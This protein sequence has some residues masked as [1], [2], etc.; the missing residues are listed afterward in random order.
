MSGT[1]S[2]SRKAQATECAI[3]ISHGQPSDPDLAE[4]ELEL[5]AQAVGQVMTRTAPGWRVLS[6][7][8]AASGRLEAAVAEAGSGA[9]VYPMFMTDGWFTR[10]NLPRRL[11]AAGFAGVQ[12]APFGVD[13]DLPA[14]AAD[15]L[16]AEI[17]AQG[18]RPQDTRLVLAAHGSGRSAG[19]ARDTRAF[20]AAL[21]ARLPLAGIF[22]GFV[23]ESP[24]IA[25]AARDLG[26]QALCLPFFAA[27]RGHVMED[28][29]QGLDA[30][31]FTG[32][33]LDPLGL[34]PQ[35]PQLVARALCRARMED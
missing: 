11:A 35:V 23:E 7:T 13:P 6:A 5:L 26:A 32:L 24:G 20:A 16:G 8:L 25:E 10:T 30:A 19:P 12:L 17:A 14:L 15:W 9:R 3:L 21:G 29:P 33:R 2:H 31:G 34:H 1:R 28:L 27:R 18:W 4:A 22:P